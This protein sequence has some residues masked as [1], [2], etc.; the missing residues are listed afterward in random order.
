MSHRNSLIMVLLY[1][2]IG[3]AIGQGLVVL[4]V[5]EPGELPLVIAAWLAAA[6]LLK[7]NYRRSKL[8]A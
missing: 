8:R 3:L 1:L 4:L 7:A 6:V 2:M 5:G